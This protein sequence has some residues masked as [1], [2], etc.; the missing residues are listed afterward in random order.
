M[1]AGRVD[2]GRAGRTLVLALLALA[3]PLPAA[4]RVTE[5]EK[6]A[7][8]WARAI[9]KVNDDHAKKPGD[10]K[11]DDLAARVPKEAREALERL[12]AMEQS[13]TDYCDNLVHA[14]NAALD[15]DLEEEFARLQA[16]LQKAAPAR[17]DEPG[18][19][20]S[21]PRFLL[22]GFGGLDDAYLAMFA[23]VFDGV[24]DAYDATFGFREWSKVPGKKIRVRLH[25]EERIT[26][27]PRFD[28]GFPFHSQID[29][30]V[31][32]SAVFQSPTERGQFL[33]YGLCH[34]L[35]HLVAMWGD[36]N[37]EEDLH[38]WAHYTG[39]V[40]V[41]ALSRADPPP[42]WMKSLGDGRWRSL[43][44]LRT[45]VGEAK[46]ALLDRE[47]VLAL[48]LA[49]HDTAGPRN[50][51]AAVNLMDAEKTGPRVNGVRYYGV[52]DLRMAL[53]KVIEDVDLRR[54]VDSLFP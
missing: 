43:E 23:E 44:T 4:A 29:F 5:A 12:L 31:V 53:R 46:P 25:L 15:L 35:G 8:L 2:A 11:E 41:D 49:L 18:T 22:R 9:R 13:D 20:L 1:I 45:E 16:R 39:C 21:R 26:S 10:A 14:A 52:K 38:T 54:D 7:S 6:A 36:R 51:G 30:P 48:W 42:S 28:P 3:A 24:L 19:A 47:G 27:P 50:L 32:D 33:L 17:L 37:D 40:V 34:E